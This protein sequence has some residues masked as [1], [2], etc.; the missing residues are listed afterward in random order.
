MR[1][2]YGIVVSVAGSLMAVGMGVSAQTAPL[3]DAMERGDNVTVSALLDAAVDVNASQGDG[4]T[5]L[6]WAA[7]LNDADMTALLISADAEIAMSNDYGATPLGLASKNGNA[8]IIKQLIDAGA[9]PNDALYAVNAGETPLMLAA[10]SGQSEAVAA[11][12]NAGANINVREQWNGQSAL[13][14]AAVEGHGAV[15][16]TLLERGADSVS[17]THLTL[18]TTPY[19]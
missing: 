17:Y 6:Q 18:P 5:A 3:A 13:M 16:E 11:L 15:V 7:Y 4:T 1:L 19:V 9:D 2:R 8:T 10:R 14:W 12:L